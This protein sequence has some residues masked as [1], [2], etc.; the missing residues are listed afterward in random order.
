MRNLVASAF[1]GLDGVIH[2]PGVPEE[3]PS[4]EFTAKTA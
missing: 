3:D 1:I 2:G 4:G